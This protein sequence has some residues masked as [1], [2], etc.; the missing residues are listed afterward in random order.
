MRNNGLS[1]GS[2]QK[3]PNLPSQPLVSVVTPLYNCEEFLAECIESVLAQTYT[4]W[5]FT[6]VNNCSTDRSLEIARAYAAKDRRIRVHTN[7]RFVDA[8]ANHNIAFRQISP[9]SKYCKVLQADDLLFPECLARMVE[10]AEANPSVG[11]VGAYGQ[12]GNQV[13]WAGFPYPKTFVPG[14]EIC[15]VTL[16]GGPYIFG[17][18]TSTLIRSDLARRK[19]LYDESNLHADYQVCFDIL[20]SSDFGFVHQVLTYTRPRKESLTSF[21]VKFNT[22]LLG[23]LTV[24]TKYGPSLL[25]EKEYAERL[26]FRLDQYYRFLGKSLL[27]LRGKEF[28]KYHLHRLEEIGYPLDRT[29]L[30]A[31]LLFEIV[32]GIAHPK[33]SLEGIADWWPRA[34]VRSRERQT[35]AE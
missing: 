25:T 5:D 24:L 30:V 20:Q 19:A 7:E 14:R 15:R 27:R 9:E 16:L 31:A 13:L 8:I 6:I 4:H 22:Y 10:V 17:S 34:L 3:E 33:Q 29:R 23:I 28:W 11:M 21:S 1:S 26:K 18:P 2:R 32:Y 35:P 12:G